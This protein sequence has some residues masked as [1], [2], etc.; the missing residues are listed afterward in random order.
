VTD[1]PVWLRRDGDGVVISI[2][3]QPGAARSAIVGEHG[4][5][6]KVRLGAPPVDG[7]ANA[8]LTAFVAALLGVPRARVAVISGF[9]S[10]QKRVRIDPAEVEAVAAALGYPG[11]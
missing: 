6:L 1:I 3:A 9:S 2:H 5:A 7:K 11:A 10:R 4:S 8:E